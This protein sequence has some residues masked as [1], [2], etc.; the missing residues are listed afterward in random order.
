MSRL[1][2]PKDMSVRLLHVAVAIIGTDASITRLRRSIINS[3]NEFFK[4]ESVQLSLGPPFLFKSFLLPICKFPQSDLS[5]NLNYSS[6]NECNSQDGFENRKFYQNPQNSK[7]NKKTISPYLCLPQNTSLTSSAQI[8]PFHHI[9][10][11]HFKPNHVTSTQSQKFESN[12]NTSL[13]SNMDNRRVLKAYQDRGRE[14]VLPYP[15]KVGLLLKM[16]RYIS[17]SSLWQDPLRNPSASSSRVSSRSASRKPSVSQPNANASRL[18]SESFAAASTTNQSMDQNPDQTANEMLSSFFKEKGDRPLSQIEYEGVRSLLEKSRAN[19]TLQNDEHTVLRSPTR[20]PSFSQQNNTTFSNQRVLKNTSMYDGANATFAAPDYRPLYQT[21]NDSSRVAPVKRVYQFSG[22]PSPYKTRIRAPGQR[23]ARRVMTEADATPSSAAAPEVETPKRISSTAT[24]LL[25]VLDSQKKETA[26]VAIDS[27]EKPLHNPY[28]KN[29]RRTAKINTAKPYSTADDISKTVAFNKAKDLAV[30]PEKGNDSLFSPA[31]SESKPESKDTASNGKSSTPLFTFKPSD[32]K[33]AEKKPAFSFNLKDSEAKVDDTQKESQKPEANG[34]CFDSQKP[35]FS[36]TPK[37]DNT[38]GLSD[39]EP[40]S[41]F[42]VKPP[43]ATSFRP[44]ES[45]NKGLVFAYPE[46]TSEP[47]GESKTDASVSLKSGQSLFGSKPKEGG[48]F[49]NSSNI[50]SYG[51]PADDET[52]AK[53]AFSFGSNSAPGETKKDGSLFSLSKD[54]NGNGTKGFNFGSAAPASS[55][56]D[57]AT[58]KPVFNFGAKAVEDEANE[59]EAQENN[60]SEKKEKPAFSFGSTLTAFGTNKSEGNEAKSLFGSKSEDKQAKDDK[61][62]M[63]VF[64]FLSNKGPAEEKKEETSKPAFSFGST[65]TGSEKTAG[66]NFGKST[67]ESGSV[68]KPSAFSDVKS[69]STPFSFGLT[70]GKDAPVFS[71]GSKKEEKDKEEE[72]KEKSASDVDGEKKPVKA[73]NFGP[74]EDKKDT[75]AFNFGGSNEKKETNSEQKIGNGFSFGSLTADKSSFGFGSSAETKPAFSFGSSSEQ[76]KDVGGASKLNEKP[77]FSFSSTNKTDDKPA[78]NFGSSAKPDEKPAFNFGGSSKT[79]EKPVLEKSEKPA[80]SFGTSEAKEKPAFNFGSSEAKDKPAF[81]FGSSEAKDKPAFNFGSSDTKEKPAFSFGSSENKE[82]PAFNFG[83]SENK[84]KPAFNFGSSDTKEK[85]A[86]NFGSSAEKPTFN[87][88][89][90]TEAKPAF[91][92]GSKTEDKPAFSFGGSTAGKT[93]GTESEFKFP[94][95][96]SAN[97]TAE[98]RSQAEEYSELFKF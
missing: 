56:T 30:S 66:I 74:S 90:K 68:S 8:L 54:D 63:P 77:A 95:L 3:K 20:E 43:A 29:R 79:E 91:N 60:E 35:A 67:E 78:F 14:K 32:T 89:S 6:L 70:G 23:K 46:S 52:A 40:T 53:P 7:F 39:K 83:S 9:F 81:N 2:C 58:P 61:T 21:F 48:L 49:G 93:A 41:L 64:S 51:K 62:D 17:G 94:E 25:S 28:A 57:K 4:F 22:L 26:D 27:L 18:L 84:D 85:P 12:P 19:T 55:K 45:E 16:K 80:F 34:F 50:P 73:F 47:N 69:N 76:A 82:K 44:R 75:P 71:F 86:F 24:S 36:F 37:T 97:I 88:G 72:K 33:P 92:F 1:K 5:H 87:F 11:N 13:P 65:T 15:S 31:K 98:E 59:K 96:E 10:N 42:G 38:S